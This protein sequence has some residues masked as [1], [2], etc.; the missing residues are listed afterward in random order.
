MTLREKRMAFSLAISQLVVWANEQGLEVCFDREGLTH[1][2]NSLHYKGLAK[3][4]ISYRNGAYLTATEEYRTLGEKWESM[5][6]LAR[7]GGRFQDGNHFSFEHE[8]IK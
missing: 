1:M 8:G 3:D 4:I 5:H 6:P 2:K 7:W